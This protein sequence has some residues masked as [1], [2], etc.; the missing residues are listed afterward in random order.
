MFCQTRVVF[1]IETTV[2]SRYEK[3]FGFVSG[4]IDT[5]VDIFSL[6]VATRNQRGLKL[7]FETRLERLL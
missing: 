3:G 1:R 7:K 2:L 5:D 6:L 4:F